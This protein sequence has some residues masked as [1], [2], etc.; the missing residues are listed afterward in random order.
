MIINDK[1]QTDL[2]GFY[3]IYNGSV[4]NENE[5]NYGISHLMEHLMCKSFKE[6]YSEFDRFGIVWN[7]YTSNNEI[8]FYITGLDE[9]I[10]K[11]RHIL[12]ESL[13]NF[14]ISED[15][16][17]KEKSVVIQEYKDTFQEQSNSA[18]Y[19]ALRKFYNNYGPIGKLQSLEKITYNDVKSYWKKYLS[20]PSLIINIS[21]NNE[22]S[23]YDTF[24]LK[25]PKKY[26]P[27]NKDILVYEKMV[28][29]Q[30]YSISGYFKINTD[31]NYVDFILD[32]LSLSMKSPFMDEIREKRGLTYGVGAY[33]SKISDTEGLAAT[34]LITTKEHIDEVLSVYK[35][36]LNNPQKYL[37]KERFDITR[38]YYIIKNKKDDISRYLKIDKYIKPKNW[39]IE[40]ILNEMTFDKIK[41]YYDK[42][43]YYDNWQWVID[44]NDF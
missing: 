8:V 22:F 43:F 11:Y 13:L 5:T 1:S 39:Q 18:Y 26:T 41:D 17:E 6:Y 25:Y 16:F 37:T 30:K 23:G 3:V 35:M 36:I 44:K 32:M 33:I 27:D 42:Y 19:N 7:A 14:D 28:D 2:S 4:L 29:F 15:E 34:S 21:K 38:D 24:N 40:T 9:Y 10:Y 20:K 31:I 12:V